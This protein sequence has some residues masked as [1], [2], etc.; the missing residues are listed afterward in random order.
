MSDQVVIV[1]GA[2]GGLGTGLCSAF[3][4]AGWQAVGGHRAAPAS[5]TNSV[6]LDVTNAAQVTAVIEQTLEK[7]GRIDC[8]INNAGITE[9]A[10][11]AQMSS[12]QWERVMA[13]NLKGAFLCMQAVS[14]PMVKQRCGHV[15][16]IG[17]FAARK[18]SIGQANYAAAKAGLIGLGES[19]AK[20]LGSRNVRVN[21]VLPG[22][23]P[24][25]MT[26]HLDPNTLQEMVSENV[27]RRM[28]S[29]DEVARFIVF[30]AG[31][32]N[33]SGQVFQLDSRIGRWC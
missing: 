33:I 20:E 32:E 2:G 11:I 12:E 21:T 17:S 25:H 3:A 18:G 8:L 22:I 1:T 23:L 26:A 27:L 13:V 14:M 30:L 9:D 6:L 5:A 10:S 16:N 24:T 19:F 29:I 4:A 28:N 7:F 31:T 15:I